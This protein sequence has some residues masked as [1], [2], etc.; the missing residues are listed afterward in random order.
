MLLLAAR[1]V[2]EPY[3]GRESGRWV[4]RSMAADQNMMECGLNVRLGTLER[5]R[6]VA[7]WSTFGDLLQRRRLARS[8]LI[9][10]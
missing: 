4:L 8:W 1:V 7:A 9:R 6:K 2:K 10:R 3:D 5:N